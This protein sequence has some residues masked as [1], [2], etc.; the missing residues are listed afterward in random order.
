MILLKLGIKNKTEIASFQISS[1]ATS[2]LQSLTFWSLPQTT[3]IKLFSVDGY[4]TLK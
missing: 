3:D 2:S 4:F 1:L